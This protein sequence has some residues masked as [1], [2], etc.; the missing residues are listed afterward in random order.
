MLS[1]IRILLITD[2]QLLVV[3]NPLKVKISKELSAYMGNGKM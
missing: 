2:Q 1:E 3:M